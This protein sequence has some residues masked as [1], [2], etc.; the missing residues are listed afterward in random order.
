VKRTVRFAVVSIVFLVAQGLQAARP[1]ELEKAWDNARELYQ[2]TEYKHSIEQ[3]SAL[4]T[5]DAEVYQLLGQN[6]FMLGEYKKATEAFEK[7]LQTEPSKAELVHWLGRAYGRR[8]ETAS[9]LTAPGYATKARQLFEQAVDLDPT[10]I[11]ASDDLLDY[12]LDAP[13]FMGGGLNKAE[14]LARRIGAINPAQGHYAEAQIKDKR[15]Q[16]AEA[17]E[18]LRKAQELAPQQVGRV[19]DIAHYLSKVGK[20]V[21]SDMMF[22]RAAK[23]AP[24]DPKVLY[25]RAE[26]YIGEH[27]NGEQARKLLEQYLK[28]NLTP[29][30]PTREQAE[31]LLKKISN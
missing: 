30:L 31:E 16:Y 15:K 4:K 29:D 8:A 14:D 21:E 9:F 13:G 20:R 27:R 5:R 17:E 7:A 25:R 6:Y 10:N 22:D 18:H 11:A 23:M 1:P 24:Q 2:R 3:L 19:L 12:Y 26:T 28:S